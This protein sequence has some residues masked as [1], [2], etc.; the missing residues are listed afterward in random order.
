[1]C[2]ILAVLGKIDKDTIQ[3]IQ[4][5]INDPVLSG[6]GP[7]DKQVIELTNGL[8]VFYRL[9]I[10]D[11]QNG[12]Q[13]FRTDRI[14]YMCNGEIYNHKELAKEYGISCTTKSDC[15]I[16]GRLYERV[17]LVETL[18]KLHG[19]FSLVIIEGDNVFF[20][21]DRIGIRPLYLGFAKDNLALCS[22]PNPLVKFC[23]NVSYFSP[24]HYGVYNVK[25]GLDSIIIAEYSQLLK[26]PKLRIANPQLALYDALV[27][28]VKN[29]LDSDRPICCLLSGGLDSS[30][31]TYILCTILK[32][33][34]VRTY[35]IGMEGS[36][37]LKYARKV[38]MYLGTTHTEV[39]FTP[40]QGF[41]VIPTVIKALASYDITTVRASVGMYLISKYIADHTSDKVVFSGEGSDELFQ[42]YLYFHNAPSPSEGEKESLR[43]LKNIHLYDVLRADRCISTN[44][45]EARV[46]FLDANVIKT[47]L[48]L[49]TYEKCPYNGYEKY[50]LRKAFEGKLPDEIIWRR[51]EGFSDGVSSVKKPWYAY[52]QDHV[53]I[54]DECF[55][56][57]KYPSKEAMYYRL[58]FEK[59]FPSYNLDIE[60]WMPKWSNS[61]DPSGRLIPVY[62]Q[63]D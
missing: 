57:S 17:G 8:L 55:N 27:N 7:D 25:T 16:I 51:K 63:E 49:S 34:D 50:T 39:V 12:K 52:I 20:A 59:L 62:D 11:V 41:E 36:T 10:H 1:M 43:L 3:D 21:R 30:I 9:A 40:K 15:E 32:P 46:P 28:A 29:R 54:P 23:H 14:I 44:G 22:V 47:G 35:S 31:I 45:L 60:Y 24:G 56:S 2:G 19:V 58:I 26:L 4:D 37:D 48:S 33:K 61:K 13:P 18:S 5:S 53:N 6:R 42:G 38:A